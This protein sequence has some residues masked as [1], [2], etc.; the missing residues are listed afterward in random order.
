[1]DTIL[2][3][4]DTFTN[5]WLLTGALSSAHVHDLDTTKNLITQICEAQEASAL[6]SSVGSA[7][8]M[9]AI[10]SQDPSLS[11]SSQPRK[12]G[13]ELD[14]SSTASTSVQP[15]EKDQTESKDNEPSDQVSEEGKEEK[16]AMDF[17]LR[18]SV[19]AF[20]SMCQGES[21]PHIRDGQF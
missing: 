13:T 2:K 9:F 17:L 5:L 8:V 16:F 21:R 19:S 10:M 14:Q 1:M 11:T 4:S 20:Q 3:L 6:L 18:N 12:T 15:A 7:Y